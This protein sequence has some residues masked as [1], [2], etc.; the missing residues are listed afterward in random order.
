MKK[1]DF[2]RGVNDEMRVYGWA[3][4]Q[5]RS[6]KTM[7]N[8]IE[9]YFHCAEC[10][11]EKPPDVSPK[12]WQRIQVGWTRRGFQVWCV[13]HEINVTNVDFRGQKVEYVK[14]KT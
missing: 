10:L 1:D 9:L 7:D 12:E 5:N 11:K 13:R 6:D 8:E 2:A 3:V 14:E 4:P